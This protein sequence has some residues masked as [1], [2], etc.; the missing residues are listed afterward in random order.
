[1]SCSHLR[2]GLPSSDQFTLAIKNTRALIFLPCVPHV[3]VI[4]LSLISS[5]HYLARSTNREGTAT[6]FRC[7][8]GIFLAPV[9]VKCCSHLNKYNMAIARNF[10]L[11]SYKR[12]LEKIYADGISCSENTN[13]RQPCLPSKFCGVAKRRRTRKYV[14]WLVGYCQ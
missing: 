7:G 2:P 10:K 3:S 11:L 5:P 4:S 12:S 13:Y 14:N 8:P 1:M 9:F 6:S